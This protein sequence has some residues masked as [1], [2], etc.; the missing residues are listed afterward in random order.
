MTSHPS[1]WNRSALLGL[2]A[3]T[4]DHAYSPLRGEPRQWSP[5]AP[6]DYPELTLAREIDV[7]FRELFARYAPSRAPAFAQP[8]PGVPY[9][10]QVSLENAA[11][12]QALSER[13]RFVRALV[14]LPESD[15][16]FSLTPPEAHSELQRLRTLI[17]SVP[18]EAPP[19]TG[20]A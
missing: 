1:Y 12:D 20:A 6:I 9:P 19:G 2:I 11:V 14:A 16:I 17:L 5:Q 7:L 8:V 15:A 3:M 10:E 4:L 18:S 13:A